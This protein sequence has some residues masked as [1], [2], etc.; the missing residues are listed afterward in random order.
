MIIPIYEASGNPYF[1][2]GQ[3]HSTKVRVFAPP[4]NE[5]YHVVRVTDDT[6]TDIVIQMFPT[7]EEA[8][9]YARIA[10]VFT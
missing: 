4:H 10:P 3:W 8:I 7:R 5:S 1:E 9:A 6:G 2:L